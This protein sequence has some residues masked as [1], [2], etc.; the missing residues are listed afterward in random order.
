M[1]DLS[2]LRN[3]EELPAPARVY[4]KHLAAERMAEDDEADNGKMARLQERREDAWRKLRAA[5]F[6]ATAPNALDSPAAQ[7]L[8]F[9][10]DSSYG[11]P[12]L[13]GGRGLR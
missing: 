9:R 5:H 12:N 2:F 10:M 11:N 7:R 4:L 3:I 6:K 1:A 8:Q 13:I